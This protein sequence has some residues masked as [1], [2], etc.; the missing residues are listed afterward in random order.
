MRSGVVFR[1][2]G[3]WPAALSRSA[4]FDAAV[5]KLFDGLPA[6]ASREL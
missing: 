3:F 4:H 2:V 5:I 6:S 1:V